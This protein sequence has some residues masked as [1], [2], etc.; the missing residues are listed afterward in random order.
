MFWQLTGNVAA[1][2]IIF[3]LT[4]CDGMAVNPIVIFSFFPKMASII[5]KS[6]ARL[7]S[8]FEA[9]GML[10]RIST[11]GTLSAQH[12]LG[13]NQRLL[14]E[15][16]RRLATGRRINSGK[17]DPAGLIASER[18]AAALRRLEAENRAI[19]RAD[20]HVNIAE[21]HA[22]QLSSMFQDLEALFVSSANQAGMSDAEI[23]A[24]QVQV[25]SIVNNIQ[26]FSNDAID[27][28]RGFN[29]PDGGNAELEA[30]YQGAQ[31][32]AASVRS[33]GAYDLST[34]HVEEGQAAVR[35][36]GVDIAMARGR[37]GT[38][39]RDSL[40]PRLRSNQIAYENISASRSRIADADYA[41]ETSNL[42][43]AT[44]LVKA[45]AMTLRIAQHQAKTV[46]ALLT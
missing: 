27:S 18:L 1:K 17:D 20:S 2:K 39:Q 21:G 43:R 34:G 26:R 38:F 32:A 44:I 28:L 7:E 12:H 33:G 10:S 8:V 29:L 35:A 46:L 9:L 40:L 45:G 5:G 3:R 6:L 41:V 22:S 19:Q 37:L 24:N 16:M 42:A 11:S 25:D 31:A 13:R 36:A 30:L 23:A 14:F 15:V 4:V